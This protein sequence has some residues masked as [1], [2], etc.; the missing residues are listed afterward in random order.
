MHSLGNYIDV[1]D[2][3]ATN[4]SLS[5]ALVV[6][7]LNALDNSPYSYLQNHKKKVKDFCDAWTIVQTTLTDK[8]G[9]L[10][11][12]EIYEPQ[13]CKCMEC[14]SLQYY[15]DK[16]KT[17]P[18]VSS[19][20]RPVSEPTKEDW[21]ANLGFPS[22]EVTKQTLKNTMQ[23]LKTMVMETTCEYMQDYKQSQTTI[24]KP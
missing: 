24:L 9:S 11:S 1:K 18:V 16:A 3:L 22:V 12:K 4:K 20:Q 21:R 23:L 19:R 5:R 14:M 6:K 8:G 2:K 15:S 17:A 7:L 13:L 10:T